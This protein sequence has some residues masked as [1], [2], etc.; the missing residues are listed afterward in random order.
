[1]DTR[2]RQERQASPGLMSAP[3]RA[4]DIPD[5]IQLFAV[6]RGGKSA[7]TNFVAANKTTIR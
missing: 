5:L 3:D 1:M 2:R 7:A 4:T 6:S